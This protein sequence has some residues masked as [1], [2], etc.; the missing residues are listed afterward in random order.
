MSVFW[1]QLIVD[2]KEY[3]PHPF[4]IPL[5]DEKTHQLLPGIKIGDVGPK[6]GANTIDNGWIRMDNVKV[7]L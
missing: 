6:N 1:A 3:G 5:R 4:I 7:P 2:G